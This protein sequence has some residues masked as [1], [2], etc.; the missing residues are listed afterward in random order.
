MLYWEICTHLTSCKVQSSE[1]Q[2]GQPVK[3]G[4]GTKTLGPAWRT[5]IRSKRRSN[6]FNHRLASAC[7]VLFA[8]S[9]HLD[10]NSF[11]KDRIPST[12]GPSVLVDDTEPVQRSSEKDSDQEQGQCTY[13]LWRPRRLLI[14]APKVVRTIDLE[15]GSY[16]TYSFLITKTR[17][18][19]DNWVGGIFL[20]HPVPCHRGIN[21]SA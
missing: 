15:P 11:A 10:F 5:T 7:F 14:G 6:H 4:T 20:C 3:S 8:F 12:A 21:L 9:P 13:F 19:G 1:G 16:P 17:A 2:T 18:R